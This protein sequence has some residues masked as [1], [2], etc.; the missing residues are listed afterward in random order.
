MCNRYKR[1]CNSAVP[2][3][4]SQK[5][6]KNEGQKKAKKENTLDYHVFQMGANQQI[7]SCQS[8]LQTHPIRTLL[9]ASFTRYRY[10]LEFGHPAPRMQFYCHFEGT[11]THLS[12]SQIIYQSKISKLKTKKQSSIEY[13]ALASKIFLLYK[14]FSFSGHLFKK[15]GPR[16]CSQK[17]CDLKRGLLS[18]D[19]SMSYCFNG[20]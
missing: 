5:I 8:P 17:T 9:V 15:F 10:S 3:I 2:W 4:K 12:T 14:T 6:K 13:C 16:H 18:P 20:L 11:G 1:S 7:I 19:L